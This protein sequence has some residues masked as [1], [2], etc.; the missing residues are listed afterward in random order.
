MFVFNGINLILSEV[1]LFYLIQ[2]PIIQ[3]F[4]VFLKKLYEDCR[5]LLKITDETPEMFRS[6]PKHIISLSVVTFTTTKVYNT[7]TK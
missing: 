3:A 2:E 7:V 4:P 5:R 1:Q 6:Y